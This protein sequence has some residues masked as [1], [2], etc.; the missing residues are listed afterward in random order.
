[1]VRLA[2]RNRS[3][4]SWLPTTSSVYSVCVDAVGSIKSTHWLRHM[5]SHSEL[6]P[7]LERILESA[8]SEAFVIAED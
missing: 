6:A 1:M 8:P 2:M 5:L 4:P 7:C 3:V